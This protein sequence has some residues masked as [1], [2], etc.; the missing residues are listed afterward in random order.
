MG[1]SEINLLLDQLEL[2]DGGLRPGTDMVDALDA[3]GRLLGQIGERLAVE[4]ASFDGGHLDRLRASW[5]RMERC[6][7]EM[8]IHR[9]LLASEYGRLNSEQHLHE[10]IAGS[11]Q[12][13]RRSW[14][15]AG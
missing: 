2:L 6:R 12:P 11:M 5:D 1:T 9:K 14:E 3:R 13:E 15:L 4:P 10:R 8:V 7:A